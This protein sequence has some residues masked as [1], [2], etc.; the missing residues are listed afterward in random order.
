LGLNPVLDLR[1]S[2]KAESLSYARPRGLIQRV[3]PPKS[4][5]GRR[6]RLASL[7]I[8]SLN[9]FA[10]SMSK[11]EALSVEIAS[12]YRGL[13]DNTSHGI[14]RRLSNQTAKKEHGHTEMTR[15]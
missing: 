11:A 1:T 7:S 6:Q 4:G 12:I 5:H 9:Q 14:K 2:Q 13:E 8:Q 10:D 3:R 15:L